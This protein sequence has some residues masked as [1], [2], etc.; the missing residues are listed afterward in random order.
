MIAGVTSAAD[1]ADLGV[2]GSSRF[3]GA[4]AGFLILA[5]LGL[6]AIRYF[7]E[8]PP[9]RG[10]EGAAG[11]LA[12]GGVVMATGALALLGLRD[13]PVLL[14]PAAIVLVPA[15]FLSFALVT[16]PLLVPA[17]LLFVG[18]GR[19]SRPDP[20][21]P[22]RSAV[23]MLAVLLL[24]VGAAV[25]LL[26]REDPRE[27][28]DAFGGYGTSDIITWLEAAISLTLTAAALALGWIL[29]KPPR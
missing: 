29:S 25:A 17:A 18:Y 11:S 10:A 16:L 1:D 19:R 22:G 4:V 27:Y 6:A 8:S 2:A 14:L 24:L 26:V 12:L 23:V 13:R 15:S 7:G 20:L 5:G 21:P 9:W 3:I 28:A